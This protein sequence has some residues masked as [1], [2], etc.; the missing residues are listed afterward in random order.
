MPMG[1]MIGELPKK[2]KELQLQLTIRNRVEAHSSL[3]AVVATTIMLE[4]V[5]APTGVPADKGA[6]T[7]NQVFLVAMEISPGSV[8]GQ[9]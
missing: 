9:Y 3:V 4:V 1:L 5:V 6:K 2:G 8:P 7:T